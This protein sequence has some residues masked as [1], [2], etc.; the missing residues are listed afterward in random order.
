MKAIINAKAIVPNNEEKFFIQ[1]NTHIL[2][3][4]TINKIFTGEIP[5]EILSL[6]E[7]NIFD[8]KDKFV[9]PGFINIHAHGAMGKD[10]MDEDDDALKI[11]AKAEASMGV[12]SFLPT[13]M[14]YDMPRIHRAFT[15]IRNAMQNKQYGAK[16]L[17]AHMEGPFV[18]PKRRGAQAIDNIKNAGFKDIE[19]FIDVIKIITLAPEITSDEF[20][21]NAKES[22]IILSMGHSDA[23][24]SEALEA[25]TKNK[26]QHITHLFNGMRPFHHRDGGVVG[27]A[28][29]TSVKAEI[30][31]DNVHTSPTAQRLLYKAKGIEQ[32]ILITD[33]IRASCL[34]DGPSELGGQKVTVKGDV[35]LL[36][37][38]ALAGSVATMNKVI[39]I[40]KENT[41][42]KLEEVI[43]TVTKN[44]AQSLKLYD[45]I[46]SLSPQKLSD[47][48][49]F[50]DNINIA[51]TFVNGEIV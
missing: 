43:E 5:N 15:R 32:I 16:I 3:D 38:G 17:G 19:N 12:T 51:A 2:F 29:D 42:A 13:T 1:N 35:A 25:I 41:G 14:T 45:K 49:V 4:K 21:N 20:I 31:A 26:V 34:G 24:Y 7:E 8:A 23:N 18:N 22:G 9:S 46:G 44:P 27:A 36:D 10:A 30:I 6:S 11:F 28:F 50:D 37:N 33:S 40:F 48:V 39:S 47:L